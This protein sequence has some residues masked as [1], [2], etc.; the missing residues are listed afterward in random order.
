M[1]D[2]KKKVF[3]RLNEK[4][5]KTLPETIMARAESIIIALVYNMPDATQYNETTFISKGI[6]NKYAK[7]VNMEIEAFAEM[8]PYGLTHGIILSIG[9]GIKSDMKTGDKVMLRSMPSEHLIYNGKIFHVIKEWDI[10][11]IVKNND[12]DKYNS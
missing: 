3:D 7:S 10:S 11:A 6:L 12:I 2:I 1:T 5:G 8:Y 4:Q 9:E